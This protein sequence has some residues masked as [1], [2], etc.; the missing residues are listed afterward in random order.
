MIIL[1]FLSCKHR[2]LHIMSWDRCLK[3]KCPLDTHEL[4]KVPVR[5]SNI[6]AAFS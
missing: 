3:G 6:G 1:G 5:Q 2:G 4:V